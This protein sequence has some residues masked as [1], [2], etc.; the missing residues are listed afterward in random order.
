VSSGIDGAAGKRG[1]G[2][3]A[4]AARVPDERSGDID[5]V[6]RR[7][8]LMKS[9]SSKR[10]F[11]KLMEGKP[12]SRDA[13]PPLGLLGRTYICGVFEAGLQDEDEELMEQEAVT[14]AAEV[15]WESAVPFFQSR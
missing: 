13:V 5:I 8:T 2:F 7:A 10:G 15:L 1:R 9:P 4:C 14:A 11:G 3:R 12:G 6:S